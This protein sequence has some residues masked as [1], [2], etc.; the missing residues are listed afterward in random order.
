MSTSSSTTRSTHTSSSAPNAVRLLPK[1]WLGGDVRFDASRT[2]TRR[3]PDAGPL[4]AR[5]RRPTASFRAFRSP[6]PGVT[7]AF[8]ETIGI[9][10]DEKNRLCPPVVFSGNVSNL[11]RLARPGLKGRCSGGER[12]VA[13]WS[14]VSRLNPV[15][16]AAGLW[17]MLLRHSSRLSGPVCP[18]VSSERITRTRLRGD[19]TDANEHGHA[20]ALQGQAEWVRVQQLTRRLHY[21]H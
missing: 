8:V 11:L 6:L 13:A 14:H 19:G 18:A 10:D 2:R 1:F 4:R 7:I 15:G 21:A 5:A 20:H 12:R 3:P 17:L 9:D 16:A